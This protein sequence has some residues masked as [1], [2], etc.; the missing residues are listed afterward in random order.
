MSWSDTVVTMYDLIIIG[1]G[2]AGLTAAI[3]ASRYGLK[4]LVLEQ[5]AVPGQIS[6]AKVIENYPGFI[7][8][9]GR[10][11]MTRFREHALANGVTI[12]KAEVRKVEEAV[13][14]K[15]IVTHEEELHALAV[16]I[17][18][19]ANPKLLGVPGEMEFLGKGVSYCATCDG[20]FFAD[21]EVLVVGGGESAV[22]D[23]M[24]LSGIASKVYVVHRR[25]NLRSC[26][27][28]QQKAFMKENIEFIWNTVVEEITGKD[29]VES[30]VLRNVET[31]ERTEKKIDGIF[32]YVGINP[33]TGIVELDKN[34]KGFIRTNERMETSVKGIYAAGDCRVTPLWQVVTAVADGA[35]AAISAQEYVADL[36]LVR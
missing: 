9:S 19:G 32:I 16:I 29:A 12:K 28:L 30:V 3:Y 27:V 5:S 34:E 31:N 6:M 14:E 4:T 22:T 13:N 20:S 11:L 25:D 10:E 24:I 33:N 2:P 8:N 21:Q 35:V 23:A 26:S 7:S 36:K 17:A 15:I 1:A 18:T